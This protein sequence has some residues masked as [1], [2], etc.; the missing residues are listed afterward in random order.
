[1]EAQR[2][3]GLQLFPTSVGG[4]LQPR[5]CQII[6]ATFPHVCG[7]IPPKVKESV[8]TISFPRARGG[9][10]QAHY[11]TQLVNP[12]SC[13]RGITWSLKTVPPS[14]AGRC[15]FLLFFQASRRHAGIFLKLNVEV[16]DIGVSYLLRSL[17]DQG[18]LTDIVLCPHFLIERIKLEQETSV[19]GLP[20][21]NGKRII[22][23]HKDTG[24]RVRSGRTKNTFR[25]AG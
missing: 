14:F 16:I 23:S 24:N 1:M 13:T 10:P 7:G 5:V 8:G 22:D 17:I 15:C 9:E 4:S 21:P 3:Q 19:S 6:R 20:F 2:Q 25:R 18:A 12:V 11:S